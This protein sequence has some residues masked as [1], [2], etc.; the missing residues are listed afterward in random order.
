MVHTVV[1]RPLI[2]VILGKRGGKRWVKM[3]EVNILNPAFRQVLHKEDI[4]FL[5]DIHD[6]FVEERHDIIYSLLF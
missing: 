4:Q 2:D 1:S 5:V 3:G 6:L